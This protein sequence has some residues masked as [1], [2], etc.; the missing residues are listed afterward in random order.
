MFYKNKRA[1]TSPREH[2][3]ITVNV[4]SIMVYFSQLHQSDRELDVTAPLSMPSDIYLTQRHSGE[5]TN[6]RGVS[7]WMTLVTFTDMRNCLTKLYDSSF[8]FSFFTK[9]FPDD[10]GTEENKRP[11]QALAACLYIPLSIHTLSLLV[12]ISSGDFAVTKKRDGALLVSS[13]NISYSRSKGSPHLSYCQ[14][15]GHMQSSPS[16]ALY[17][18]L[19]ANHN[20]RSVL[21]LL[22]A[23][24]F[25]L[26]R[27]PS[28][29]PGSRFN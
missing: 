17:L 10:N 20:V 9:H 6:L 1:L 7:G 8:S 12:L 21:L 3:F 15:M 16:P 24:R 22:S 23:A 5:K 13:L 14:E 11:R 2:F 28:P 25:A 26:A 27:T 4:V 29:V 19:S 18:R